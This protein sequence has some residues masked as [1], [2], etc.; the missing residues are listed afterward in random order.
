MDQSALFRSTVSQRRDVWP[1][2]Y[3]GR[4]SNWNWVCGP[5]ATLVWMGQMLG[6]GLGIEWSVLAVMGEGTEGKN[7]RF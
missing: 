6:A 4:E 1:T 2:R 3:R 5:V 7:G